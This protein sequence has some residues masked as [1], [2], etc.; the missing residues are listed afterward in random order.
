VDDVQEGGKPLH[1]VD[2]RERPARERVE[3]GGEEAGIDEVSLVAALVEEVDP[4]RVGMEVAEARSA[5]RQ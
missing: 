2:D 5:Q 1:L 3:L 4:V